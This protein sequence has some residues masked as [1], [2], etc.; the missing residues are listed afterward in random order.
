M[1]TDFSNR[2]QAALYYNTKRKPTATEAPIAGTFNPQDSSIGSQYYYYTKPLFTGG[3]IDS[4]T[5]AGTLPDGLYFNPHNGVISGK[6]TANGTFVGLS[7]TAI[8]AI[9]NDTTN[10]ADIAIL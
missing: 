9:G 10:T 6:P 3:L 5:L 1:G 7:V 4:Y 2:M 8:N